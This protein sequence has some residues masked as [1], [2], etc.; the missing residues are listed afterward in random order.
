M[1]KKP[2]SSGRAPAHHGGS[3]RTILAIGL[4]QFLLL[5]GMSVCFQML[6]MHG[7][8]HNGGHDLLRMGPADPP[9]GGGTRGAP[10]AEGGEKTA[11]GGQTAGAGTT[12][13]RGE[14]PVV[15]YAV[16]ITGCGESKHYSRADANNLITQGAVV[17]RHSIKLAHERSRY[18]FEMYAFIHPS[19]REC[20][21]SLSKVGYKTLI[22][23][24][25]L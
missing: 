18:G 3:Y 5:C 20:S 25:P 22:R 4:F 9:A 21:A 17:L 24:T 8:D 1:L 10:T 2:A 15:A 13:A 12:A 11:H 14:R 6:A 23:N 7:V 16:T 19:A